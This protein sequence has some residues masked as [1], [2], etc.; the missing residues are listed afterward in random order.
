MTIRHNN[1]QESAIITANRVYPLQAI[2]ECCMTDWPLT[3]DRILKEERMTELTRWYADQTARIWEGIPSED[4]EHIETGSLFE[5]PATIWGIGF[6]YQPTGEPMPAE[7]ANHPVSFV[8]PWNTVTP[9]NGP[10]L[11]PNGSE[12]TTG[13]G[14]IAC[15]IGKPGKNLTVQEARH[16]IAGYTAALDM[17]ESGIHKEHPRF[18]ARAKSFDTF[19]AIGPTLTS[20]D[21]FYTEDITVQT[22]LNGEV[23]A[24][25]HT[26]RML[27][28]IPEIVAYFSQGTTLNPGDIILTGTPGPVKI[29]PGDTLAVHVDGLRPPDQIGF[30]R[31]I[32]YNVM[33]IS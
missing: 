24:E 14:E 5:S 26:G 7:R 2:N 19:C 23:S 3:I 16:C 1:R 6:N 15:I 8:K 18:L 28:N 22:I 10:I 21:S 25:N 31:M 32:R 9:V 17:T 33:A 11:V 12:S 20:A 30:R 29:R 27:M 4:L 13:E